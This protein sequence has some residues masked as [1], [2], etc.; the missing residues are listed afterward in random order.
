[1]KL[2]DAKA[3]FEESIRR[4]REVGIPEKSIL[5]SKEEVDEFFN[6]KPFAKTYGDFLKE[7]CKANNIKTS[8]LFKGF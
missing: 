1:M 8:D 5:K 7:K 4:C 6:P 2:K 3:M